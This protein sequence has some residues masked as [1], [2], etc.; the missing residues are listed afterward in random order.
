MLSG[1]APLHRSQSQLVTETRLCGIQR[2]LLELRL[3]LV[4]SGVVAKSGLSKPVNVIAGMLPSPPLAVGA[5]PCVRRCLFAF[6]RTAKLLLQLSMGHLYAVEI[7]SKRQRHR[8]LKGDRSSYALRQSGCAYALPS[9]SDGGRTC[10]RWD[11]HASWASWPVLSDGS[12]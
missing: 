3:A 11:I 10:D 6:E 4:E 9:H 12:G 8:P 5:I 7:E 1:S 2:S